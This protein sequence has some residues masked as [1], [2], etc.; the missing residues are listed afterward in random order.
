[1]SFLTPGMVRLAEFAV[2]EKTLKTLFKNIYGEQKAN[3]LEGT[4]N[5]ILKRYKYKNRLHQVN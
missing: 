3:K 4:L 1:M 5:N 2:I